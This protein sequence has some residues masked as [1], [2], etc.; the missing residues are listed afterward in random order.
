[1][2]KGYEAGDEIRAQPPRCV[3]RGSGTDVGRGPVGAK[4]SRSVWVCCFF[5]RQPAAGERG[6]MERA[7]KVLFLGCVVWIKRKGPLEDR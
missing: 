3:F 2:G 4:Q 7:R 6:A 5:F 1:M